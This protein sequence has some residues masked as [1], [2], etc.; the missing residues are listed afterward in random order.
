MLSAVA[1]Q[2]QTVRPLYGGSLRLRTLRALAFISVISGL[3][4]CYESAAPK[5]PLVGLLDSIVPSREDVLC[6]SVDP[7]LDEPKHHA[8]KVRSDSSRFYY[9][10][11][12]GR[13]LGIVKT[14]PTDSAG[15]ADLS[16]IRQNVTRQLG[17]PTYDGDDGHGNTVVHWASDSVCASLH[18]ARSGTFAQLSFRTPEF[19]DRCRQRAA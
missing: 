17:S 19:S 15:L 10:G 12:S 4:A 7:L 16:I 5:G 1:A 8:C 2:A 9:V 14:L 6:G 3:S 18:L 13:I 11:I